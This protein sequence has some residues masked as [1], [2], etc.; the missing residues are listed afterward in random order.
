MRFLFV[1]PVFC[2]RLPSDSTSRWT[3]LPGPQGTCTPKSSGQHHLYRNSARQGATRHAWRTTKK[4]LPQG[5]LVRTLILISGFCYRW[6]CWYSPESLVARL[7][8]TM[9]MKAATKPGMISYTPGPPMK[10][11]FQPREIQ[12]I[13]VA[14]PT[15]IPA[16]APAPLVR[17]HIRDSRISGP[18]AAPK[19]AQALLTRARTWEFGSEAMTAATRPTATTQARPTFTHSLSVA[20]LRRNRR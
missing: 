11:P 18:K 19:P 3:P 1:G 8:T 9:A 16:M 6:I 20:S 5:A 12:I 13:T 7:T 14:A 15:T 4:G 17:D 10:L 2:L